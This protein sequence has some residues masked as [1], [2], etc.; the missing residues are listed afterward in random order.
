MLFNFVFIDLCHL[1]WKQKIKK[2]I[3]MFIPLGDKKLKTEIKMFKQCFILNYFPF[4]S[5]K[6]NES[7]TSKKDFN[8]P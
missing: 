1:I 5:P 4:L 6:F 7:S 8:L 2:Q 3:K